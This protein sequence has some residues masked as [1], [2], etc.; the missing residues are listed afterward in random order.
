MRGSVQTPQ[1]EEK[2]E[3]PQAEEISIDDFSKW[4]YV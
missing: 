1:E 4:T 3:E 2:E